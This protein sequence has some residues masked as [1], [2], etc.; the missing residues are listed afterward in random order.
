MRFF[1]LVLLLAITVGLL[2][3]MAVP[4]MANKASVRIEAP[5]EVTPGST[6]TIK[7]HVMHN[8]NNWFHY[9]N[10]V[11]VSINNS[12]LKR[13]DFSRSNRPENENFTRT[14]TYEVTGPLEITAEA[15]CNLHGSAGPATLSVKL[16]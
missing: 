5:S 12:E 1:R 9:T 6:I 15:N 4:A 3:A 16:K 8:G 10:W 11:Q 2:G 14:V 7:L 13:W